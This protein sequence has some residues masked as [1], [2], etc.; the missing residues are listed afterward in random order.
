MS[1]DYHMFFYYHPG[2][3][4][5]VVDALCHMTMGSVSHFD[6]VKK[7]LAREVHKLS[8]LGVRLGSSLDGGAIVH[9]NSESSLVVE[10]MSKQHVDLA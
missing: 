3:A 4:N 2:K 6:E 1:K 8:R 7:D 9:E 5:V 10:V